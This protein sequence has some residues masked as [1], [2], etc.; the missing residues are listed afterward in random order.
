MAI[1]DKDY[2]KALT[3]EN[4]PRGWFPKDGPVI[5]GVVAGVAEPYAFNFEQLAFIIKQT[6][7]AT[8]TDEF[9]DMIADEFF[10]KMALPRYEGEADDAYRSRIFAELMR[11]RGT[12]EAISKALEDLTGFTPKIA[13]PWRPSDFGCWSEL[14]PEWLAIDPE[15]LPDSPGDYPVSGGFYWDAGNGVGS[16][17]MPYQMFIDVTR[18]LGAA[19]NSQGY[20]DLEP[21]FVIGGLEEGRIQWAEGS[22]GTSGNLDRDILRVIEKTRAAGTT[23]WVNIRTEGSD[24]TV[25]NS[26]PVW[27]TPA[28]NLGVWHGTSVLT[29]PLQASDPEGEAVTYEVV[30]GALPTGVSL[31][32]EGV[33]T[34]TL[35]DATEDTTW[36]FTV[37]AVDADGGSSERSFSISVVHKNKAPVWVTGENLGTSFST[38]STITPI[39]LTA[40]DLESDPITYS[41]ASG[42]VLP[43]GLSLSGSGLLTGMIYYPGTY[44]FTVLASDGIFG[45]STPRT[46][47][48]T[49]LQGYAAYV[50]SGVVANS[51]A[52]Q[53]AVWPSGTVAGDF[54]I[55]AHGYHSSTHAS[56]SAA[57]GWQEVRFVQGDGN[58]AVVWWKK[59]TSG[60]IS[61]PP[62]I[63]ASAAGT[64]IQTVVYRGPSDM[65]LKAFADNQ[66]PMG[67]TTTSVTLPSFG[68]SA[69]FQ[70]LFMFT[71]DRGTTGSHTV[72]GAFSKRNETAATYFRNSVSD[73]LNAY[74]DATVT[75]S[76]FDGN[77]TNVV[78]IFEL[79]GPLPAVAAQTTNTLPAMTSLNTPA[80]FTVFGS[81]VS[82]PVMAFNNE[83]AV[84]ASNSISITD[85]NN[86]SVG[87]SYPSPKIVGRYGFSLGTAGHAYFPTAWTFEGSNDGVIWN[88]IDHRTAVTTGWTTSGVMR[89]FDVPRAN[90]RTY[91][92]HRIRAFAYQ[93][94]T[95][96]INEIEFLQQLEDRPPVWQT[97]Q[98]SLGSFMEQTAVSVSLL[99]VDPDGDT[100]GY[101]I[102]SGALPPGLTLNVS[103]G[104]ISGTLTMVNEEAT[105]DFVVRASG[106]ALSADRAFSITVQ[107]DGI[108]RATLVS[109]ALSSPYGNS[110]YTPSTHQPGD[111]IVIFWVGNGQWS[112]GAAYNTIPITNIG[113]G[114][115]PGAQSSTA[116][117]VMWRVAT[118]TSDAFSY[119]SAS[120][121]YDCL[122]CHIYRG[123]TGLVHRS[124]GSTTSSSSVVASGF[125]PVSNTAGM[126]GFFVDGQAGSTPTINGVTTRRGPYGGGVRYFTAQSFDALEYVGGSISATNINSGN[127]D[128]PNGG[129]E[130]RL[131]LFEILK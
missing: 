97:V 7:L 92:R 106:T 77:Y 54:A 88:Y 119:T 116:A 109:T 29:I 17:A 2:F 101:T 44:T 84:S 46:F 99:A 11:P 87:R 5:N 91:D 85:A 3:L 15:N 40:T 65:C 70:G 105:H 89:Y 74:T 8:A 81:N 39:Q 124:T 95:P 31:S 126:C 55:I 112:G 80:G 21:E 107:S 43:E 59:L 130:N 53:T 114:G 48:L 30:D 94:S 118:S 25:P 129:H 100:V 12:R 62:T 19:L 51:A 102:S 20:G 68:V 32:G 33:L 37:A 61:T 22:D 64:P 42:S 71:S 1:G 108:S 82:A 24:P 72:P 121:D 90:W 122:I 117:K 36:T 47:T 127:P 125:T 18:P 16:D 27:L 14:T 69:T 13:E 67:Q 52:S 113:N 63:N 49:A 26:A 131:E 103:T 111:L 123:A 38:G 41:V 34:G 115:N 6:R 66:N 56:M 96:Y 45:G 57:N 78:A 93:G 23:V 83:Y 98:G 76:G 10:G 104:V 4:L 79:H 28:G 9:L 50:Q 75:V 86:W 73:K 128:Y 110:T 60:D 58:F 120:A 35:I